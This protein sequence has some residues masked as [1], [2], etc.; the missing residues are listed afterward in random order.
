MKRALDHPRKRLWR[1]QDPRKTDC[2]HPLPMGLSKSAVGT[3]IAQ[4]RPCGDEALV[5]QVRSA[6]PAVSNGSMERSCRMFRTRSNSSRP[7][8]GLGAAAAILPTL[9]PPHIRVQPAA[10]AAT[11]PNTRIMCRKTAVVDMVMTQRWRAIRPKSDPRRPLTLPPPEGLLRRELGTML[12][13]KRTASD[14][15]QSSQT[16]S[17]LSRRGIPAKVMANADQ[18]TMKAAFPLYP[19][20]PSMHDCLTAFSL[21]V[22]G[23]A[24]FFVYSVSQPAWPT[25]GF[26]S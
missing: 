21:L 20:I 9:I 25:D 2:Q 11:T 4:S 17:F 13:L 7:R 10:A 24:T 23:G 15:E 6:M 1:V 3:A 22:N 12:A 26:C 18:S 19:S 16:K 8:R 5:V 14:P